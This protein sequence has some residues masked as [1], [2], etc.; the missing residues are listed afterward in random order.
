MT[1]E[2]QATALRRKPKAIEFSIL[3]GWHAL[4][5]GAFIV[6]YL[7][8]DEDTYAMHQLAGYTVLTALALR[9]I[10]ALVAPQGSPLRLRRPDVA[11]IRARAARV[12]AGSNGLAADRRPTASPSRSLFAVMAA[13]LLIVISATAGSGAI[14]DFM[15]RVEDVHAAL[16]ELVL[17]IVLAHV[18]IVMGVHGLPKW[19]RS[20]RGSA[21]AAAG[22]HSLGKRP[23]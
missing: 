2:P 20:S 22:Q 11:P 21:V 3:F 13:V 7:T 14:A 6:A 18:A 12:F 5:S 15:P 8:G 1:I 9:L 17:W 23:R 19:Q 10:A 16:G 4:L